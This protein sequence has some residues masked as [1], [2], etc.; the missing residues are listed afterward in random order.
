MAF[1]AYQN[2]TS[3]VAVELIAS[4]ERVSNIK[5][6]LIANTHA[7]SD[8][9][10]D[11]YLDLHSRTY[12]FMKGYMLKKGETLI[13]NEHNGWSKH[14]A[15]NNDKDQYALILK[16]GSTGTAAPSADVMIKR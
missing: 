10:V 14:L 7:T 11:L 5:S 6:I 13:L 2:I 15:F 12:Y 3:A 1:T 9:Y 16:L 8:I 4:G